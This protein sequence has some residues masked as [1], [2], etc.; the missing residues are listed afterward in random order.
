MVIVFYTSSC[1]VSSVYIL[2]GPIGGVSVFS[3]AAAI[4]VAAQWQRIHDCRQWQIQEL[5]VGGIIKVVDGGT[6]GPERGAKRRSS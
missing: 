1:V 3:A 4:A 5:L 2:H 6:E